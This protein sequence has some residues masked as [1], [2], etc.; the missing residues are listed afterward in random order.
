GI[1]L[2]VLLPVLLLSASAQKCTYNVENMSADQII[3]EA[4][5]D[6][7]F[8]CMNKRIIE[9]TVNSNNH[10]KGIVDC[11]HP[12][13]PI[14]AKDAYRVIAEEIFRRTDAGGRCPA[15][16][17]ETAALIDYTLRLLQQ[18]QPRELRR[19]LGYLG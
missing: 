4:P 17:P 13:H 11:L 14:C 3:N 2:T 18:R 16:S 9:E 10:I 19:G 6:W 8:E 7:S 1:L 15:C 12:D 5:P